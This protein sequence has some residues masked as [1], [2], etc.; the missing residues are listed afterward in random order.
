ML[1]LGVIAITL[2]YLVVAAGFAIEF[3]EPHDRKADQAFTWVAALFWPLLLSYRIG[4][5]IASG[6]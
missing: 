2:I 6:P 5:W 4:Q 3:T 1:I